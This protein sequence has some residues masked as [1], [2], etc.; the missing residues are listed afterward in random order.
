MPN[1]LFICTANQFRSPLAAAYFSF[2]LQQAK[3]PGDWQ[4][5][6]A[7]TW[8]KT[9]LPA[10]SKAI[11]LADEFRLDL[12]SHQTREVN[13]EIVKDSDLILVMEQGQKES[14]CFEFSHACPRIYLLSQ[15]S[16]K[17]AGD[18]P[19]P[20]SNNF[21]DARL[22]TSTI[23]KTID[24]NFEKITELILLTAKSRV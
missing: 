6:S 10:H 11:E 5:S 1:I 4:V 19:D 23:I 22:I 18:I 3:T 16:S 14:L 21:D 17:Y 13:L 12:R 7:G 24:A 20:A 2:K 9:G 15:I 8:T